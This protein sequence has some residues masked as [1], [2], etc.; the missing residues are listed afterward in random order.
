MTFCL[1]KCF[2]LHVILTLAN[3]MGTNSVD[4]SFFVDL[5]N[6]YYN[7]YECEQLNQCFCYEF[8]KQSVVDCNNNKLKIIPEGLERANV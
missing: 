1:T 7:T 4:Y 2:A 5:T 8:H 3:I 6:D